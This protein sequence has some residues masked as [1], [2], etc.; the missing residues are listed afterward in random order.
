MTTHRKILLV[1]GI[2]LS[3]AATNHK[4]LHRHNV[5]HQFNFSGDG[6]SDMGIY[7]DG[8]FRYFK[9]SPNSV[10]SYA[11]GQPGDMS[12][13]GDYD[14]DGK[15]DFAIYRPSSQQFWWRR[16]SDDMPATVGFGN[17]GDVPIVADFDG[18]GKT[19]VAVFRPST[20][21]YW[22]RESSSGSIKHVDIGEPGDVPVI[23]DFDGD[24]E[25]D[26]AIFR[27]S[28]ATFWY[29]KS[30]NGQLES[31]QLGQPGD[32]PFAGDFD[33]DGIADFGVYHAS[34]STFTYRQS[35]DYSDVTVQL[36]QHGDIPIM[37]DFDADGKTDLALFRPSNGQSGKFIYRASSTLKQVEI[38]FGEQ[39]DSPLGAAFRLPQSA[40]TLAFMD[41][42]RTPQ[43]IYQ[44]G[45][46][47][48]DRNGKTQFTANSASFFPRCAYET[49]PGML[50]ELKA[51]GFN[52]FKPWNGLSLTSVIPE[53]E[54]TGM[55]L[56]KQLNISPCDFKSKLN[57]EPS[58]NAASQIALLTGQIASAANSQA[59]LGWYI[60]EEPTGC[61]NAPAS[62]PERLTNY[63][64]FSAAI[65][66]ID[67]VHPTF[68]LDISLPSARAL[69]Q[70]QQFNSVGEVTA[71][72]NYPF[73]KGNEQTL[74][75]SVDVYNRLV[76]LNKQ[77]KPMW[78][79]VQAFKVQ[80]SDGSGW[81]MPTPRQLRAEIFAAVV[82]GATGI[83]DF[84]L[85]DWAT[86]SAQV[87][88]ISA[89]PLTS[90][91][92]AQPKDAL[93]TPGDIA[94]SR[95]LWSEAVNLN[96]E[97]A[98]LQAAILS[99]TAAV[100]YRV[101]IAGRGVTAT[102]IRSLLKVNSEGVYTMLI[103]NIDNTP[104]DMQVMLPMRPFDLYSMDA[105]GS[106][107]PRDSY[108]NSITDS[109][110]GFGIRIY[111]FK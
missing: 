78:V 20:S 101:A 96:R 57:C 37:G 85:D 32:T 75:A 26:A 110:E 11:F 23:G 58:S 70:W 107:Y 39:H 6:A 5:V 56:I 52:C 22:Y 65:K 63:R 53:A 82:S 19:D 64:N 92:N 16:S 105:A 43:L 99:P 1:A 42:T 86:R 18:D 46:P 41:L 47:H 87:I 88:G 33:G 71:I 21:T 24:G 94:S 62:C 15:T 83:I 51:A 29:T 17:P 106:R 10:R 111:E 7:R 48:T 103:V 59:I 14:G 100:P 73:H 104:L 9:V 13:P 66:N 50:T 61:I 2:T 91:P 54:R 109:I 67:V 68:S 12:L 72:D 80:T 27:V 60:E 79:T 76:A 38:A 69:P 4:S 81:T 30:G 36:G 3:L 90:Y 49:L 97:L 108:G 8:Q 93:A 74:E 98:R 89:S 28:T 31:V 25:D 34:T 77:K 45:A 55:Q 102:P 35:S 44:S 84:A 40:P 95:A